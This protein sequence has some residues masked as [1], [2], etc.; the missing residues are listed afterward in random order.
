MGHIK[1]DTRSLDYSS[2][3]KV[4]QNMFSESPLGQV[5]PGFGI[6]FTARALEGGGGSVGFGLGVL[7]FGVEGFCMISG[8]RFGVW[9]FR[10]LG[11]LG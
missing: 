3:P 1:G 10:L 6:R 2:Y 4:R 9:G 11:R 5:G 8:F 7:G